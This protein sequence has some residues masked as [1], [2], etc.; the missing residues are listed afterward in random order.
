[1]EQRTLVKIESDEK[2]CYIKTVSRNYRPPQGFYILK[3]EI[4][5]AEEKGWGIIQDGFCF[6]RIGFPKS[7][8]FGNCVK[9]SFFWSQSDGNDGYTGRREY[10]SIPYDRFQEAFQG[11]NMK[12][13][14]LSLPEHRRPRIEF[15]SRKNLRE[16]VKNPRLR[17]KLGKFLS[18]NFQWVNSDRIVIYDDFLPYSFG[19]CEYR[20]NGKGIVGGMILHGQEHMETAYYGMHT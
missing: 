20:D 5:A 17:R 12:L 19:F 6:A 8:H 9:I 13:K 18:E 15:E 11:R 4:L 2:G 10:L 1:M 3:E 14:L 16:V 7:G